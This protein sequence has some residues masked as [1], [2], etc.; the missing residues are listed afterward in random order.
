MYYMSLTMNIFLNPFISNFCIESKYCSLPNNVR[1]TFL[2]YFLIVLSITEMYPPILSVIAI[3][4]LS[5]SKIYPVD[6]SLL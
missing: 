4:L 1:S 5:N 3:N 6:L 2:I